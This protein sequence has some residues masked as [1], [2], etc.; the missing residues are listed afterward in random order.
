MTQASHVAKFIT[1]CT[2]GHTVR[3][4]DYIAHDQGNVYCKL[5][6]EFYE[7]R[8]TKEEIRSNKYCPKCFLEL[9]ITGECD[10]D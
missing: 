1:K 6:P 4:D 3:L 10:C 7:K 5:C 8:E 9:S 2:R